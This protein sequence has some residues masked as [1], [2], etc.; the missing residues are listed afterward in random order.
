M[1]IAKKKINLSGRDAH[2][3]E[4]MIHNLVINT[5]IGLRNLMLLI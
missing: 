5:L 1:N 3:S 4:P 2:L